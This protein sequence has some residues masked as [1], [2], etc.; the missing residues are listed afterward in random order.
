MKINTFFTI[1]AVA[2]LGSFMTPQNSAAQ[3]YK[4]RQVNNM[5]GMKSE[6][7]I[8]VK[9][10][11]KRTEGG[12]I[13]GIGASLVT[14]EQC[15]LQRT[16]YL[17]EKKK[18][19]YIEPFVSET[20]ESSGEEV[21]PAAAKNKPVTTAPKQEE[22]K[23]G[24]IHMYYNITDTGERKK[25]YGFTARHIWTTMKM[26]PSP[27]ACMMKDSMIIKTDG[28]YIDMPEFNC[29]VRFA[30]ATT[31]A[32]PGY[33]EPACRDRFVNHRSGKGKLGFALVEKR[34]MIMG[35]KAASNTFETDLETLELS[36]ARLD[37]MLF[38]IPPD[39]GEA[40]SREELEDK[41]DIN[42]L[43]KQYGVGDNPVTGNQGNT[44]NP[45]AAGTK[46][47]GM[48][49]IGV[50]P[51]KAEESVETGG[52]Q[53][54][55]AERLNQGN[56]EAITVANEEEARSR[57]CDYTLATEFTRIKQAGKVGGLLKAIKNADPSAASSYTIDAMM[58]LVK[59]ADGSTK[60]Q[61]KI[62]GKYEGK[63]DEAAKKAL[64]EGSRSVLGALY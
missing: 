14:I 4:L 8:Y 27:D 50:F 41:M 37:S 2:L 49:R 40:K 7:T 35:G 54:H 38:E 26:K 43:M 60:A 55:L 47:P 24:A 3:Q 58:K 57:D 39:F 45:S 6:S 21:K 63:P 25:M 34:T 59:L 46:K 56:V 36:T 9:G 15:D 33:K 44:G 53:Q 62:S 13:M 18:L 20:E 32:A 31:S 16:V 64:D 48:V 23:G 42:A 19:Y 1:A 28:W 5:M 51:P 12:G 11:R 61:P 10:M 22:K 29:P 30:P 17:N 52:W